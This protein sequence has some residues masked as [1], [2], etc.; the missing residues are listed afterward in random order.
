M[1]FDDILLA[2]EPGKGIVRGIVTDPAVRPLAGVNVTLRD[3]GRHALTDAQGRFGFSDV[4]P[5]VHFLAA[6]KL[7]YSEVQASV[8][9]KADDKEPRLTQLRLDAIPGM[10]PYVSL[11]KWDGFMQCS[12][13][14]AGAFGTGCLLTIAVPTGDDS[15]F[16]STVDGTPTFLQNELRWT[17]TQTLGTNLCMRTYASKDIG[18]KLLGPDTCGPDPILQSYNATQL[19]AAGVGEAPG[20]ER[21]VYVASYF[22][23][24][25][26]GFALN[27]DFTVFTHLF[28]NFAPPEGWTFGKDGEPVVPA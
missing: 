10:G 18:G 17:P 2:A 20:I 8:E 16:Y 5:G 28:Y 14:V 22:P 6:R 23:A 12:F 7:G 27:Q 25:A 3:A 9:V 13:I 24:N 21:V 19:K 4:E 11:L 1:P 15:R 26:A